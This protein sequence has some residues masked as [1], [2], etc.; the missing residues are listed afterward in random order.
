MDAPTIV[1][2]DPE[3]AASI[4]NCDFLRL[5]DEIYRAQAAG[6]D[7]FHLDVMDGHFVPNL[8]I[9]P[10]VLAA[11]RRSTGLPLDAHLMVTNPL[12]FL[13]PAIDSG[14]DLVIVHAE[15]GDPFT[16]VA[17]QLHRA[18]R[19]AGL[20]LNPETPFAAAQGVLGQADLVLLMAVHPGFGGQ[21]FLAEVMQ[22]VEQARQWRE[23]NGLPYRI[24]VDGGINAETGALARQNGADVLVA[25]SALYHASN[26]PEAVR[27]LRGDPP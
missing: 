18:G 16:E 12:R 17:S 27:A 7:R 5:G 10:A 23:W 26:L 19:K 8:S 13:G 15:A 1:Q 11:V 3:I 20:A 6:V 24:G 14:M 9:G 2:H 22:K 4:L 25:G 21:A